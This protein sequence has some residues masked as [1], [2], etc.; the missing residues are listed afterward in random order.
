MSAI[1]LHYFVPACI[2][3]FFIFIYIMQLL[4]FLTVL[5]YLQAHRISSTLKN[6]SKALFVETVTANMFESLCTFCEDLPVLKH[7]P[8]E[9]QALHVYSVFFS[10]CKYVKYGK[11][12]KN[13]SNLVLDLLFERRKTLPLYFE[14][15]CSIS[16]P[17]V[18]P[19]SILFLFFSI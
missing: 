12:N 16:H 6:R 13:G 2:D 17:D 9:D 5:T 8:S 15:L 18:I 10:L 3:V 14:N 19:V 4:L 11:I 1:P 7:K